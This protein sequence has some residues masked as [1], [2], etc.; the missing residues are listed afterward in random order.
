MMSGRI[1]TMG[2]EDSRC[3]YQVLRPHSREVKLESLSLCDR[4]LTI[5][6]RSNALQ[7]AVVYRLPDDGSTPNS[8]ED[9]QEIAF[10][11][12]AYELT[13][14]ELGCAHVACDRYTSALV[15]RFC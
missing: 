14:G 10:D 1:I 4:Y 11:E 13:G 3:L 2:T 8:L 5:F 9:G 15:C 7:R 6:E 12:P